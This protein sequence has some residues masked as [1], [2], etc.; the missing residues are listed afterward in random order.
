MS[1]TKSSRVNPK[2]KKKYRVGSWRAYERGLRARGDVTVWFAEEVLR[3][4]TPPPTGRRGGQ[5]RY[6]NLAILTALTLRIL[7][8]LPL[9]QTEGFVASLLRL[10][11]LDLNAPDHTT[12]SRRNR[13]VLVPALSRDDAGPIHLIVDSTGLKIY[14][15][16]AWCSRKHRKTNERAGWR[17]LHIGVDDDGYVVA[18]ALTDNTVDDAGPAGPDRCSPAARHGRRRLRYARRVQGGRRHRRR[19]RRPASTAGDGVAEGYGALEAEEPA[20][21]EDCRDRKTSVAEGDRLPAAGPSR[22]HVPPVQTDPRRQSPCEGVRGAGARSDGGVHRA[23]QD[24]GAREGAVLPGR[25]VIVGDFDTGSVRGSNYATT[26]QRGLAAAS[27]LPD[28]QRLGVHIRVDDRRFL[29]RQAARVGGR[30]RGRS[31]RGGRSHG[32]AR[33]NPRPETCSRHSARDFCFACPGR[34]LY[35]PEGRR[36][37]EIL[38]VAQSS[39]SRG[40]HLSPR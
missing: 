25:G 11:G 22:G 27:P 36:A 19:G 21:R 7:F 37:P 29:R 32:A 34:H 23:E 24:V 35:T 17:K 39:S 8:H 31:A 28:D 1:S 30:A 9:R 16:G 10:M 20:Y 26:P 5:Q 33:R 6:S 38:F 15:A 18:E 2:N 4:W 13:D 40:R 12:L 14:G 3:T